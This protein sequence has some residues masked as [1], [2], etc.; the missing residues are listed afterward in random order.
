MNTAIAE[1]VVGRNILLPAVGYI[2][3][4]FAYSGKFILA[5]LD[6]VRP[7]SLPQP[8]VEQTDMLLRYVRRDAGAFEIASQR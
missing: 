4:A 7:C 1:H 3:M 2:E 6:F 5:D 8:G